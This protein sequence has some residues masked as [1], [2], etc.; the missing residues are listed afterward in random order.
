VRVTK[1]CIVLYCITLSFILV[2]LVSFCRQC[3]TFRL[4]GTKNKVWLWNRTDNKRL[5]VYAAD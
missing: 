1:F 4:V 5:C 3:R 2:V